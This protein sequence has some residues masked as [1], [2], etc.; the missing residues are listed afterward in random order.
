[1]ESPSLSAGLSLG[2]ALAMAIPSTHGAGE[3]VLG[4]RSITDI[5]TMLI[6]VVTLLAVWK[7]G[8]L[9]EPVIVAAAAFAGT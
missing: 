9:Q 7:V 1:M 2:L 8:K 6:M 5:P 3:V 4:K